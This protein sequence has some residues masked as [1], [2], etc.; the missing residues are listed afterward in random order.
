MT[1]WTSSDEEAGTEDLA[2]WLASIGADGHDGGWESPAEVGAD[3]D[4]AAV[5]GSDDSA[6][7][8]S[9]LEA[10]AGTEGDAEAT[11]GAPAPTAAPGYVS[12]FGDHD[13]FGD[14]GDQESAS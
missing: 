1:F 8:D 6:V 5:P 10:A 13:S 11:D 4:L 14:R 9:G 2:A 12:G 3:P 7:S